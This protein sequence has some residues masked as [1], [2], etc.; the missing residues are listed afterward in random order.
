[1]ST[2]D[3]TFYLLEEKGYKQKDLTDYL[4]INKSVATQKK[5]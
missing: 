4:G 5:I 1:M 2:I 3:K